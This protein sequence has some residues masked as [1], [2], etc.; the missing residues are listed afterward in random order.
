MTC[1][2]R[3]AARLERRLKVT[4]HLPIL[5]L[6]V[7]QTVSRRY[8]CCAVG[9]LKQHGELWEQ[10]EQAATELHTFTELKKQEDTAIPRRQEVH[11]LSHT[12]PYHTNS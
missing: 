2:A 4:K 11:I 7:S 1:E 6:Y 12:L 3:R 8:H 9:L 5:F 10:V